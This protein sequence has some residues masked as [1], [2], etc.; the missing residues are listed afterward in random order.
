VAIFEKRAAQVP[1]TNPTSTTF[2]LARILNQEAYDTDPLSKTADTLKAYSGWV[3]ACAST[4]SSDVR[5]AGWKIWQKAGSSREEWKPIDENAIPPILKR[6]NSWQTFG[7]LIE[8]TQLHLDLAG[9]A[10]WH[11]ISTPGSSKVAGIQVLNPDWVREPVLDSA[12]IRHV[13][14][15]I[16]VPGQSKQVLPAEDVI[17]FRY[18]DPVDPFGGL[19]PVRAVAMSHDLDTYARAYGASHLRNHAQPSGILTTEAELTKEQAA[20]ISEAWKDSHLGRNDIQVLGKG[21]QYQPLSST[22]KD[23]EFLSLARVSR[24]QILSAFHMPASRIGLIEDSSRANGEESD[25]VYSSLCLAPRLQRYEEPVTL[26]LLPRLGLDPSRY[27]FEFDSVDVADKEFNRVAASEAFSRGAI[28]LNEYRES[29]GFGPDANGEGDV[30]FIPVGS[31]VSEKPESAPIQGFPFLNES[32]EDEVE[33]V[34]QTRAKSREVSSEAKELMALRFLTGHEKNERRMLGRLRALFT[35][36][37]KLLAAAARD[38]TLSVN[39]E[40]VEIRA[41]GEEIFKK[42]EVDWLELVEGETS[43]ALRAGYDLLPADLGLGLSVSFDMVDEDAVRFAKENALDKVEKILK[44]S[45][46]DIRSL[47]SKAV[48]EG[49]SSDRLAEAIVEKYERYKAKPKPGEGVSIGR[50]RTIARTEVGAAMNFGKQMHAM[51]VQDEYNIL[52]TKTW[53]SVNSDRTR[54]WHR[55]NAI[56]DI[57]GN[58]TDT[59][60][61]DEDFVVNDEL[62]SRPH[63]SRGSG[64]NVINCRCSLTYGTEDW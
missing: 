49:W 32:A 6:P 53:L 25:R 8:Q 38:G 27:T 20:T 19:S 51:A 50:A 42:M 29:I 22:I 4:I 52:V 17:F 40:G 24:D 33:K 21:A 31:N 1:H 3:F 34:Q 36:E 41:A 55:T 11:M 12:K 23:L 57:R 47:V 59:V 45:R 54:E 10:F 62:M 37:S 30:Y 14:W 63:D 35:K 58:Y 16:Q 48:E 46:R 2:S 15:E 64:E 18:P 9:K 39:L 56:Q 43:A 7:D 44:T 60:P 28:T 61:V 5:R 26:F 13:G